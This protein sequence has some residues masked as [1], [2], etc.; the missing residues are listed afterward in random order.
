MSPPRRPRLDAP[1]EA[2]DSDPLL[3]SVMSRHLVGVEPATPVKT[4]LHLMVVRDVRHLPVIEGH[5]CIGLVTESDLLR[6]IAAQDGPLG[7]TVVPVRDVTG[8]A[9]VLPGDTRLSD[10]TRH[11]SDRR[12]DAVLVGSPDK[13]VG[14]VTATDMIHVWAEVHHPGTARQAASARRHT[15]P[16]PGPAPDHDSEEASS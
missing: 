9:L 13:L 1:P 8:P 4:A 6:G 11:M 10:A 12:L 16:S 2:F 7:H 15:F 5:R 3:R 14:I